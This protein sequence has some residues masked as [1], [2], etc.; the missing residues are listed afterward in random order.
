MT[1][2]ADP[3]PH[4]TLA[5][6]NTRE[7]RGL[8]TAY[9]RY[10]FY[11]LV[12]A[13]AERY[14]ARSALE[15]PLDG[16]AGVSGVHAA[17]L[18]RRG[19]QVASF[20]PTPEKARTARAI[21]EASGGGSNVNVGVVADPLDLSDLPVSDLVIAYHALSQI[22][23]WRGYLGRIAKLARKTLVVTVCNPRNWGVEAIRFAGRLRN[24]D[25]LEPP[26]EWHTEVL[27]PL[28]WELGQVREHVYFDCP[29]WPDMPDLPGLKLMAGQSVRGRVAQ[30]LRGS[31]E[32]QPARVATPRGEGPPVARRF[33]FGAERWPYFGGPG[34]A[35]ELLP[36]LLRHPGFDGA[37][38]RLLP[39]LAHL[40]AFVVDVRPRT[41]Q[42][43]RRLGQAR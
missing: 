38:T 21:Y 40:H 8:G 32:P 39:R 35:G 16:M 41:P 5:T 6:Q 29:W 28:L 2:Q 4:S 25:G 12:D 1:T 22:R 14:E 23:D 43:R 20:L 9:E 18:A 26:E 10:C 33:V 27:A 19:I 13:W 42:A 24:V 31:S 3:A 7:D 15:G 36:A 34:W 30:L 17:G 11:Q 37:K